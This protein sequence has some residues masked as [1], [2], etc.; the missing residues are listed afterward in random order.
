[1]PHLKGVGSY[2]TYRRVCDSG[3]DKNKPHD[4]GI[5]KKKPVI[6]DPDSL[7]DPKQTHIQG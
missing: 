5:Y 6:W 2:R 1:M 3:K 7:S 4:S